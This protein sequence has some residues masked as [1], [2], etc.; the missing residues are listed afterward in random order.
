MSLIKLAQAKWRQFLDKAKDSHELSNRINQLVRNK[1]VSPVDHI[2]SGDLRESIHKLPLND[3]KKNSKHFI[4]RVL[5]RNEKH[6]P[7]DELRANIRNPV[8]GETYYPIHHGADLNSIRA[9]L[10]GNSHYPIDEGSM[11]LLNGQLENRGIFVH[12][13]S[14][15]RLGA[16]AKRTTYLRLGT[17][18]TLQGQIKGKYLYRNNNFSGAGDEY[19]IPKQYLQH[20]ENPMVKRL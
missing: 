13:K 4:S 17:P 11:K 15:E 7:T 12:S 9:K 5:T 20:I 3:S 16:Y 1:R 14:T 6:I 2:L 19:I 8:G 18:A 10:E